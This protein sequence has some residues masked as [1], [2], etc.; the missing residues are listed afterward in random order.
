M[1]RRSYTLIPSSLKEPKTVKCMNTVAKFAANVNPIV[2]IKIKNVK[3]ADKKGKVEKKRLAEWGG[4]FGNGR[5]FYK[6]GKN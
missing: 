5:S 3:K 2:E 1:K 6:A 4:I